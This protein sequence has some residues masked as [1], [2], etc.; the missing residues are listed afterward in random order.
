MSDDQRSDAQ[1]DARLRD[2][3]DRWT[4]T[5]PA[6]AAPTPPPSRRVPAVGAVAAC[7]VLL[8]GAGFVV[9]RDK[10]DD[11]RLV[12]DGVIPFAATPVPTNHPRTAGP[13]DEP[14]GPAGE[15]C[16]ASALELHLSE[17]PG[18]YPP[19]YGFRHYTLTA[20]NISGRR[21]D[22][23]TP[24]VEL[25][26]GPVQ[27]G[28]SSPPARPEGKLPSIVI[29]PGA[30]ATSNVRWPLRP[31]SCVLSTRPVIVRIGGDRATLPGPHLC[32]DD[33]SVGVGVSGSAF[34]ATPASRFALTPVLATLE[35]P[36][37][38]PAGST[39]RYVVR[40]R[41]TSDH[42]VTL[43]PCPVVTQSL[44]SP[45][46]N[47]ETLLNCDA[48]DTLPARAEVRFAMELE[49]PRIPAVKT[50]LDWRLFQGGP[51][52]PTATQN[53]LQITA[54]LP[55]PSAVS[56]VRPCGVDDVKP[57]VDFKDV[58]AELSGQLDL[59]S[60]EPCRIDPGIRLAIWGD[61]IRD[62]GVAFT[63]RGPDR[64]HVLTKEPLG[65][66][67]RWTGPFC[68]D[69]QQALLLYVELDRV[70]R[71][72]LP[73]NPMRTP[74]CHRSPSQA[75]STLVAQW[76]PPGKEP[77]R[78]ADYHVESAAARRTNAGK[79]VAIDV[80]LRN[81][82]DKFCD[83]DV[84]PSLRIGGADRLT[85]V[86]T[87]EGRDSPGLPPG[88]R[89]RTTLGWTYWC[90]QSLGEYTA[91][92]VF[93]PGDELPLPLA[94]HPVPPCDSSFAG[95]PDEDGQTSSGWLEPV[96]PPTRR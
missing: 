33:A 50:A 58:G 48:V 63:I 2:Y 9:L 93:G 80:V 47:R 59:T 83:I 61:N 28:L 62:L 10:K 32:A 44:Q 96:D 45:T 15:L 77:C 88:T 90:G 64:A 57:A 70:L 18:R 68:A 53:P 75:K 91:H 76:L 66:A 23:T 82:S 73:I 22:L 14:P 74:D 35:A 55:E 40:L 41:N 26:G 54:P 51:A 5:Q 52:L 37:A 20:R 8:A 3:A 1:M 42:A 19:N 27:P 94:A 39:L 86:A 69:P 49:I 13:I 95:N 38:V 84:K 4:S 29:G 30:V 6:A 12:T 87:S 56:G 31:P 36:S 21:C 60:D 78:A 17:R 25:S 81:R 11:V 79:N 24:V 92:L 46:L 34:T 65:L 89:V 7:L 72:R 43:D 67:I 85:S 71:F 16:Y